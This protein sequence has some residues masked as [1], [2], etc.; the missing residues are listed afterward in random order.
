MRSHSQRATRFALQDV[1]PHVVLAS[2][3]ACVVAAEYARITTE[4]NGFLFVEATAALL[5]ILF[6]WREQE[7]LRLR[8]LLVLAVLFHAS[9]IGLRLGL[10]VEGDHDTDVYRVQGQSLLDGEY[11]RSE[12]PVG[13]VLLFGLEV[14]LGGG[15]AKTANA[16]LMIPFQC[17]TV[18]LVWA[19]RTRLSSW[20]A[21]LVAFWPTTAFWWGPRFDLV[22]TALLTAGL[23]LA[24]RRRWG[25]A[26]IALGLGTV[27]KWTPSLALIVLVVWLITSRQ[28]RAAR[29]LGVGF[30]AVLAVVYVP[31]LL[32]NPDHVLAAYTIQGARRITGESMWYVLLRVADQ[33]HTAESIAGPIGAPD[34]SNAVAGVVQIA[35]VATIVIATAVLRPR[36]EGA[37]AVA[38]LAPVV[39]LL[40]NRIFSPQFLVPI[41][42][43]CAVAGALV[44]RD[45]I[46]QLVIGLMLIVAATANIFVF[47]FLF[48]FKLALELT[49]S[50]VFSSSLIVCGF[51]IHRSFDQGSSPIRR[52]VQSTGG[53]TGL[54]DAPE[55]HTPI[56]PTKAHRVRQARRPGRPSAPRSGRSRG[57]VPGPGSGS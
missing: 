40:T 19:T 25:W 48:G 7:R 28:G 12:Y 23:V 39:F 26:G 17:A 11:P 6:A 56:V 4:F 20:F 5:A 2:G 13:A 47:P 21:V 35:L 44:L 16:I 30:T 33:V 15:V 31:F 36:P 22:P 41:V 34:W 3:A 49:S 42:A 38:A 54:P 57:R 32:W 18:A 24:L 14:W 43:C 10:S 51:L 9:W 29:A 55:Q 52:R 27:V 1:D 46:E 50:I 45:E 8:P 53:R 37:V